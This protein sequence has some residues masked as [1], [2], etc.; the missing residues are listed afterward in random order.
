SKQAAGPLRAGA[1]GMDNFISRYR[2]L[3]ILV[4]VLFAQVLG[5][6]IQIQR[7]TDAGSSRLVRIWAVALI[8]PIEKAFIYAGDGLRDLWVGYVDLRG[9]RSENRALREQVDRLLLEQAHLAE[10]AAQVRRLEVLLD[11]KQSFIAETV[12][13]RLIGS[14]GSDASRIFYLDKGSSDGLAVD[15]AVLTPKGIVG[16]T[17]QVFPGSA[18]VLEIRDPTSG[19]GAILEKS[20]LKAVLKG[21]PSGSVMLHYVM[22]DEKVEPGE[23]VLT[24]GGDRIFPRGLPIG[25]V[26]E[27]VP[28]N[29]VFLS[30]RVD[31]AVDLDRVEE[32]LVVT[33]MVEMPAGS[34]PEDAPRR[35]AEILARRLP[36]VPERKAAPDPA[37]PGQFPAGTAPV[38]ARQ[39]TEDGP[40]PPAAASPQSPPGGT[41]P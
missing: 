36:G 15:M 11:L 29:D 6:A 7:T 12:A 10:E 41:Q 13:A 30:I 38:G 39:D 31:P 18:Q 14:S 23:R 35:A 1:V 2:N 19:V 4:A 37:A 40:E 8:T 24:S 5:L 21:T 17:V 3:T 9:V 26:A 20:R 22:S 16:K 33:R 28:Q 34:L 27:I 25:T 32:V